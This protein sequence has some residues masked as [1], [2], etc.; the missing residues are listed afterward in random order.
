MHLIHRVNIHLRPPS[1]LCRLHYDDDAPLP[2]GYPLNTGIYHACRRHFPQRRTTAPAPL[3]LHPFLPR[4]S[5]HD[6]GHGVP[7]AEARDE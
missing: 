3:K 4:P 6:I 1:N 7:C 2:C 5:L